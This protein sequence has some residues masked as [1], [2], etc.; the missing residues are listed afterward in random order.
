MNTINWIDVFNSATTFGV[1]AVIA[2]GILVL[3]AKKETRSKS[4][5][6]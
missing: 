2:V 6:R 5:K 3:I 1:L 4:S